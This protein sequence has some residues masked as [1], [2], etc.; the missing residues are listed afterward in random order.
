MV[1]NIC[2]HSSGAHWI[3]TQH[4]HSRVCDPFRS[5]F[6]CLILCCSG[7]CS[8]APIPRWNMESFVRLPKLPSCLNPPCSH[9][10][11]SISLLPLGSLEEMHTNWQD[12]LKLAEVWHSPGLS[13]QIRSL[14]PLFGIYH[15]LCSHF[16]SSSFLSFLLLWGLY[17]PHVIA[18]MFCLFHS[19][20]S[21]GFQDSNTER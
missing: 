20:K 12:S 13:S 14:C 15:W 7:N 18:Y 19:S 9:F 2:T 4:F 3:A 21:L 11:P 1:S 6:F 8:V 16:F 10:F 5:V 17:S